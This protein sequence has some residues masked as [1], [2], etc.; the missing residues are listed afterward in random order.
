MAPHNEEN[1]SAADALQQIDSDRASYSERMKTPRWYYP[2]LSIAAALVVAAPALIHAGGWNL[3]VL[4]V[5]LA[6]SVSLIFIYRKR[7]GVSSTKPYGP[8]SWTVLIVMMALLIMCMVVAGA[9]GGEG[10]SL[11]VFAPMLAAIVVFCVGGP[12]YDRV[13]IAEYN[14]VR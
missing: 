1:F 4:A 3:V 10:L 8:R 14:S 5:S 13:S 9:L 2:V 12:I 11:W 7:T 6:I